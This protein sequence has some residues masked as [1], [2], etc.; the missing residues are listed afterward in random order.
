[1]EL[2]GDLRQ[3]DEIRFPATADIAG[4]AP[5]SD[6]SDVITFDDSLLLDEPT[7]EIPAELTAL[8][9][10]QI[11]EAPTS[12]DDLDD[13]FYKM[14]PTGAP[15]PLPTNEEDE[16]IPWMNEEDLIP[17]DE[18]RALEEN[19][20]AESAPS[21]DEFRLADDD[22]QQG[23]VE[24]VAEVA[25]AIAHPPIGLPPR[26]RSRHR[27]PIM[28]AIGWFAGGFLGLALGYGILM[29]AFTPPRDPLNL[30]PK[31]PSFLVPAALRSPSSGSIAQS[32]ESPVDSGADSSDTGS[33][34]EFPS[35]VDSSNANDPNAP[36]SETEPSTAVDTSVPEPGP[37]PAPTADSSV[38]NDPLVNEHSKEK[39]DAAKSEPAADPG[40]LVNPFESPAAQPDTVPS[41]D[42]TAANTSA[43]PEPQ[44]RSTYYPRDVV[45]G[46]GPDFERSTSEDEL[47]STIEAAKLTTGAALDV[48]ATA[49]QTVKNNA[50]REYYLNLTRVADAISTLQTSP[51]PTGDA[52]APGQPAPPWSAVEEAVLAAV[53]DSAKLA[54]LGKLSGYFFSRATAQG[55][56]V[57]AGAA[58]E[59]K[60]QGNV[61]ESIV[62]TPAVDVSTGQNIRV[63]IISPTRLIDQPEKN[64]V[65]V[66]R[67]VDDAKKIRGYQGNASKVVWAT[68][69]IDATEPTQTR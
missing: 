30:A 23:A 66:G 38:T 57:V 50:N 41:P 7:Q 48:P 33:V 13:D 17:E 65:V 3:S 47:R 51:A 16:A 68:L 11:V 29:W 54:E 42:A 58:A 8:E 63:P 25:P 34:P 18:V 40:T 22:E 55:G 2:V 67:I 60:Q 6:E 59:S 53:P 69:V 49:S 14:E 9:E 20:P 24:P 52:Q 28:M 35:V 19:A 12:G 10:P 5:A 46:V 45:P 32:P 31:L 36:P 44:R 64:V 39:S 43:T 21:E 1:L 62:V 26:R 4:G 61:F 56:I 27:N 15:P 37:E